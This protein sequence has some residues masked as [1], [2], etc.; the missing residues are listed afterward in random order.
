MGAQLA[1]AADLEIE[2][3]QDAL[4][5]TCSEAG[6]Q[7]GAEPSNEAIRQRSEQIWESEGCPEGRAEEHW[8]RARAELAELLARTSSAHP[9]PCPDVTEP[10]VIEAPAS[11]ATKDVEVHDTSEQVPRDDVEQ[12]LTDEDVSPA[13]DEAV[14]ATP[15]PLRLPPARHARKSGTV[16]SIISAGIEFHGTLQSPGDIQFDGCIEGTLRGATLV[17]DEEGVVHG[18]VIGD[19][20]IVH[21]RVHGRICAR[22][23]VLR[24]GCHVEGDILY[25]SLEVESGAELDGTFHH[26]ET[27]QEA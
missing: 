19:D 2:K 3:T 14:W 17:V 16:P 25:G 12:V 20:V 9:A 27:A 7:P 23:V 18:D 26:W 21:G 22:K 24:A 4:C 8:N 13:R 5:E 10:V 15:R 11:S 6:D 1:I